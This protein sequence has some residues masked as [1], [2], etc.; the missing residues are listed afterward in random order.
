MKKTQTKTTIAKT[1]LETVAISP[2]A[3]TVQDFKTSV[4][5]VSLMI[6]ALLFLFWLTVQ[7]I[8]MHN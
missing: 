3:Q 2:D 1:N 7:V 4:F 6:N 5:I 8:Q